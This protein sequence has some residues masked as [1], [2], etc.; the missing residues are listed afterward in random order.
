MR[1]SRRH[2]L[3]GLP[4]VAFGA[5]A[6]AAGYPDKPIRLIVPFAPG[7]NADLT[8]RLFGEALTKRL[9]QQVIIDNRGGAG[10]AIGAE[11]AAKS[12]PDGYTLVLGSTGTFLVSPRM[13]GGKEPYTLKDFA[14]VALLSTSSMVIDLNASN[15]IKDWPAMLAYLKANPGKLTIGHP[16]NGSTNHLA[17]LQLQKAAG[18]KFN[19]IP[20]KSNGIA[21]NDLLG[22]QIDAV[23]DQIPTSIAHIREHRL[24]AIAVTTAKRARELP[25]TP[26]LA[27]SGVKDFDET[28]PI[29]LMA[30]AG[31]PPEIVDKVNAAVA[32]AIADPTVGK[33][34][35]DLGAEVEALTPQALGAMMQKEDAAIVELAKSGLLKTE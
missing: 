35:A 8:G 15:P 4:A 2:V 19:I 7:G 27:E 32:D 31:T 18:V 23:M 25:D 3:A 33:R 16:G 26:T 13:T 10:G 12:V 21:L 22:G 20:Y 29:V 28:T 5:R 1:L 14:P 9:G 17:V 34:E 30:P 6:F 24:T 11:Q